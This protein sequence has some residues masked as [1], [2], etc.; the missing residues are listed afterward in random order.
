MEEVHVVHS[1]PVNAEKASKLIKRFL[2]ERPE[3][4]GSTDE[5]AMQSAGNIQEERFMQLVYIRGSIKE[6]ATHDKK[7]NK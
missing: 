6:M 7:L 5:E 3:T 2:S 1:K 4:H